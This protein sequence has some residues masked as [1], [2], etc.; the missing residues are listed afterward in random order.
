[1]WV[2]SISI[3]VSAYL[4]GICG[5]SFCQEVKPS[6]GQDKTFCDTARL[7]CTLL[8][9][10][11][12]HICVSVDMNVDVCMQQLHSP[13][14]LWSHLTQV[15]PN[16]PFSVS[17]SMLDLISYLWNR[18]AKFVIWQDCWPWEY[19][20]ASHVPQLLCLVLLERN[21]E[22]GPS[23]RQHDELMNAHALPRG[24]H[25]TRGHGAVTGIIAAGAF[26]FN[27]TGHLDRLQISWWNASWVC[28]GRWSFASWVQI[29]A[30]HSKAESCCAGQTLEP[31]PTWEL[32]L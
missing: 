8:Y 2:I 14:S 1:M 17:S 24:S 15:S 21:P 27:P 30:S 28:G 25:W 19:G 6:R 26:I 31:F 16:F 22:F 18:S 29:L 11:I 9:I 20:Q 7:E 12:Y 10:Y 4:P 13:A 23:Q 5:N 32:H 3:S